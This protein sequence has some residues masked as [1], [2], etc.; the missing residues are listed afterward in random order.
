ML[1][2]F[3][4]DTGIYGISGVISKGVSIFLV[5]FY[6]RVLTPNDYGII[7]L[8]AV[9][10]AI[11]TTSVS[12]QITQAVARFLADER[13]LEN[14]INVSSTAL[15]F[16][17]VA[18]SFFIIIAQVFAPF[19][20]KLILGSNSYTYIFR[21]AS[22]SMFTTGL[23]Y[24]VQN[25]LRWLIRPK[26]FMLVSVTYT[27]VT[28]PTTVFF[29]LILKTGVIGV[30]YAYIIGAFV[31]FSL[32]IYL[33]RDSYQYVFNVGKLKEMLR[34]SLPLV[35]SSVGVFFITYSQRLL[36]RGMMTLADLGLYGVATRLTSV[37]NIAFQ[38]INAA[39]V[40][41]VYDEYKEKETPQKLSQLFNFMFFVLFTTFLALSLFS[42]E[43][44]QLLTT[45]AY[46]S[47]YKIIPFLF[48]YQIFNGMLV[49]SVGMAIEKKTKHIAIINTIGAIFSVALSV[50]AIFYFGIMGVA[51]AVALQSIAVFSLQM[52]YSQKFYYVDYKFKKIAITFI[53]SVIFILVIVLLDYIN[54]I[55]TIKLIG[56]KILVIFV[57]ISILLFVIKLVSYHDISR[58]IKK[59]YIKFI[60]N[61]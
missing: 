10:S 9:V 51:M 4:K 12:L 20:A 43:I 24:F 5:P 6:T 32:G 1:K 47:A 57:F 22:F 58:Q 7:D 23:Y 60:S 34:F 59:L 25:Q 2:R 61:K 49:F 33:S 27:F 48:T 3:L 28:I 8:I 36:I 11:V 44:I 14:K 45:P 38:S 53:L 50:V 17:I 26:K 13:T 31:C 15:I 55:T 46:Y 16:N 39:L 35:P 19:W 21:V 40:P 42:K 37:V 29:V 56:V 52:F 41:I 30:F 54:N 18:Y